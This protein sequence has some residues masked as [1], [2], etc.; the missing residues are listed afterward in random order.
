MSDIV[1]QGMWPMM[2]VDE[3]PAQPFIALFKSLARSICHL[4]VTLRCSIHVTSALF[5][6]KWHFKFLLAIDWI[7]V[8][9]KFL[10]AG[11]FSA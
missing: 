1:S 3:L 7:H 9:L 8:L 5:Q 10:S 11:L 6:E 4:G 2:L